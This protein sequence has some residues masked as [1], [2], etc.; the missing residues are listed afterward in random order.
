M[1]WDKGNTPIMARI[2][3]GTTI[4]IRPPWQKTVSQRPSASARRGGPTLRLVA[5]PK[6]SEGEDK[7]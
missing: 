2:V 1:K 6:P 7:A 4:R 5:T 3:P